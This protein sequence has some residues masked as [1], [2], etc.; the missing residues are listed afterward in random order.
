M[1]IIIIGGGPGGYESAIYASK[2]GAQV[3][4]VERCEVGGTCLNVGCI[5]TKALL[6]SGQVLETIRN[7][8]SY[9]VTAG[10]ESKLVLDKIMKRKNRIVNGLTKGV[11]YSLS[12]NNVKLVRGHGSIINSRTVQVDLNG[13]GVITLSGD[14]IVLATGSSPA[15]PSSI[16][17]DGDKIVTSNEILSLDHALDSIV[18]LGGGV[19]GCEIGQFLAALGTKVTIVE[20][21]PRLIPSEDEIVSKALER[22]MRRDKIKI[23]RGKMLT[24]VTVSEQGVNITLSDELQISAQRL[25]LAIGRR[26]Y[27]ENLGLEKIGLTLDSRGFIPVNKSMETVVSGV[28]AI[29]DVISS[30][31]LAHVA[32][33]EGFVAIDNILGK[34]SYMRYNAVPR[35]VY[36][37]PEVA[38]VG[39]T[40]RELLEKG[41]NY[42]KGQFNFVANGKAKASGRTDGFVQVLADV[43]NVLVGACIVGAHATEMLQVLTLAV[44]MELTADRVGSSI[45]PHPTM[46]EGIMEALR[47]MQTIRVC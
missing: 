14:A 16:T 47:N 5:P 34:Q 3:T 35:C 25:L 41:T 24:D 23:H 27:T 26:P 45:F 39:M 6:A 15:V 40:E 4:L 36:T 32:S 17:P 44:D 31:Q 29:G 8:D 46:S 42:R 38:A 9:G 43:D 33:K 30:P 13:G 37:E 20:M 12:T 7:A 28:F 11:E 22:Q 2:H 21:L 1:E 18:I 10:G 19:I